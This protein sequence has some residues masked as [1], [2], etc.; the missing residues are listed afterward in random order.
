MGQEAR[1]QYR[2]GYMELS[3]HELSLLP[4]AVKYSQEVDGEVSRDDLRRV[5][6]CGSDTAQRLQTYLLEVEAVKVANRLQKLP[7]TAEAKAVVQYAVGDTSGSLVGHVLRENSRLQR[8]L[9]KKQHEASAFLETVKGEAREEIEALKAEA[10]ADL[11]VKH[12]KI[13][14]PEVASDLLLEINISDHHFG[15]NCW[16]KETGDAPYD[17]EIA[18][19]M[20][21]RALEILLDRAK[22]YSFSRV[23]FILGNDLL[24]SNGMNN[25]TANG[26]VVDC[27][28][29]FQ[30]TYK[31]VRRAMVEAIDRLRQVAPVT[32]NVIPGNHDRSVWTIGDSLECWY[33]DCPDVEINN[34]P[35]LRKYYSWG[36]CGF[37]FTH[38]EL[39]TKTDYPLVFATEAPEIFSNSLWREVQ[40]G[41]VHKRQLEEFH[42][43]LVRT[44]TT[45][46][47]PDAW[48]T[49]NMY[50]KNLRNSEAF[51]YSKTEGLI[52]SFVYCDNAQ[53]VL[54]TERKLI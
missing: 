24:H 32:V 51:V 15:K 48:H 11:R 41:H 26:T 14:R 17:L 36:R 1:N 10:K 44:L 18:R 19:A 22:G 8:R 52:A 35:T 6:K 25:S 54:K 13:N 2:K 39:G 46:S 4:A 9:G 27:D 31:V 50:T 42:G 7:V 49:E 21:T 3:A 40:C 34:A 37:M 43:V 30:R 53:P 28:G 45:L 47:P 38:G 20:F 16:P 29:R 5:L 33:H 12:V 23:L